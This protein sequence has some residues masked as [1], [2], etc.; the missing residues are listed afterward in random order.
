MKSLINIFFAFILV[1]S[2]SQELL[3]QKTVFN[4]PKVIGKG[5][6]S[7]TDFEFNFTTTNDDNT[8]FF[9]KALLP[10]WRK[11][12]ILTSKKR[13][14]I[15][16]SPQIASFSGQYRDADP[17]ISP[18]QTILLF[19]S[20]RPSKYQSNPMD[21]SFWFVNYPFDKKNK[22]K[23]LE[24]Q[25]YS[26]TEGNPVYPSMSLNKN[27]YYSAF[28]KKKKK[29]AIY[30]VENIN[31]KYN[32]PQIL[33]FNNDAFSDL[34]PIIAPDES[35]IVFVSKDRKGQGKSDLFVC[36]NNSGKWGKPVNLG[37]NINSWFDEG[38]PGISSD[39]KTLYFT[40]DR[41]E[42]M[43]DFK[44]RKKPI[45]IHKYKKEL[46]TPFNSLPNIWQVDISNIQNLNNE[47]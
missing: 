3:A 46:S 30:K 43:F 41:V 29:S 34:D 9:T 36:F 42:N 2:F 23:L 39:G 31:G 20:D 4:K 14:G 21:Y 44:P 27:L 25:F 26:K 1:T 13:K 18:D 7:T 8:A 32:T 11:M 37:K 10:T 33:S 6:I 17:F 22:P 15:W 38:Q 12:T 28:N 19:I 45:T 5:T 16:Q 40:S 24:G 35:F 47:N